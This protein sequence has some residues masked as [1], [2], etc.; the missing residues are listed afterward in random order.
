MSEENSKKPLNERDKKRVKKSYRWLLIIAA[1]VVVL[2]LLFNPIINWIYKD[3]IIE[4]IKKNEKI[5][6]AGIERVAYN[7]SRNGVN[8][9]GIKI[10][11]ADST[12]YGYKEY[13]LTN[14]E[15]NISGISWFAFLFNDEINISELELVNPVV[16]I[17]DSA[18]VQPGSGSGDKDKSGTGKEQLLTQAMLAELLPDMFDAFSADEINIKNAVLHRKMIRGGSTVIDSLDSLNLSFE[19]AAADTSGPERNLVFADGL[20]INVKK[21]KRRYETAGNDLIVYGLKISSSDSLISMDSIS[22]KPF[23]ELYDFFS[24]RQYTSDRFILDIDALNITQFD[25][26]SLFKKRLI[27]INEI[28]V[29]KFFMDVM[30][31]KRPP[32]NPNSSPKMPSEILSELGFDININRVELAGDL[33]IKALHKY[34]DDPAVLSFSGI[35][36]EM[37]NFTNYTDSLTHIKADG[38]MQDTA[39]M[40]LFLTINL[41]SPTVDFSY[42]GGLKKMDARKLNDYLTVE[43]KVVIEKGTIE[44]IDFDVEVKHG[45]ANGTLK[46]IYKDLEIKMIDKKTKEGKPLQS[47][48]ANNLKLRA[49]NPNEEGELKIGNTRYQKK[50]KATF[51]DVLW[52][53][54]LNGLG[55]VAGF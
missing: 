38:K 12:K 37:T 5:K 51:L 39:P 10:K 29:D 43:N 11:S 53:P 3:D 15:L 45:L 31:D 9:S 35:N 4:E 18:S 26:S 50:A 14:D 55:D 13:N 42:K 22:L 19:N 33:K 27:S 25:F 44:E 36:M 6:E 7:I 24:Y 16:E 40:N 20:E 41:N 46:P 48:L 54:L 2:L 23:R 17:H 1:V 49:S 28:T 8:L 34:F 52:L 21:H 30:T 32:V 47:F